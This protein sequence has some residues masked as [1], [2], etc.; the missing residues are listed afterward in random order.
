MA[1][2]LCAGISMIFYHSFQPMWSM[3]RSWKSLPKTIWTSKNLTWASGPYLIQIPRSNLLPW[4]WQVENVVTMEIRGD[5]TWTDL[6]CPHC[7]HRAMN[8][9]I[10][11]GSCWIRVLLMQAI[12]LRQFIDL[13][14]IK[15]SRSGIYTVTQ[16]IKGSDATAIHDTKTGV[17]KLEGI[18]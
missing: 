14:V 12:N 2:S 11:S 5:G 17:L 16:D 3:K 9:T 4:Q 1:S 10:A 6:C 13:Y 8:M 18:N 7:R 15:R